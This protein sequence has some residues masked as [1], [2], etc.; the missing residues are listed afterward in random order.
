MVPNTRGPRR[1]GRP[2]PG[3]PYVAGCALPRGRHLAREGVGPAGRVGAHAS[4]PRRVVLPA[5]LVLHRARRRAPPKCPVSLP[6]RR[7]EAGPL[8]QA[9]RVWGMV[10]QAASGRWLHVVVHGQGEVGPETAGGGHRAG[11][12][13]WRA[14]ALTTHGWRRS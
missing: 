10:P 8:H 4:G 2:M 9:T 1:L 3:S 5:L 11:G 12:S 14:S 7:A 6:S 13:A